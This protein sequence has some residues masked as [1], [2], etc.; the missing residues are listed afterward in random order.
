MS[1]LA[2]RPVA[3]ILGEVFDNY[4][5]DFYIPPDYLEV[6]LESFEGP[7]D[8][9]L[10]IIRK[11]NFQICNL[12]IAQVT[13]QYMQYLEAYRKSHQELAVEY[14]VMAS[15]LIA[16]KS[17]MLL[18]VRAQEE[19]GLEADPRAEL[20]SRLEAYALCQALSQELDKCPRIWRDFAP[21]SFSAH[22]AKALRSVPSIQELYRV[23]SKIVLN[24]QISLPHQIFSDP[25][26]T[27][28]AIEYFVKNLPTHGANFEDLVLGLHRPIG[29][30]LSCFLGILELSK[31]RMFNL[32]QE[33]PFG[34]LYITWS[35][36]DELPTE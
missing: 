16:I 7:L 2:L 30:Y 15:T 9:L 11:K 33:S 13:H 25:F 3:R 4:P 29:W 1:H 23:Y 20:A 22:G 28:E 8:L 5:S 19:E 12:P 32:H 6:L 10:Y 14:L 21:A 26:S 36:Q 24:Y 35:Y 17:R 31:Q 18:P 27:E 34:K